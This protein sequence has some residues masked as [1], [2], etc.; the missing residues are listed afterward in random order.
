MASSVGAT[1][2]G[3][4]SHL[5]PPPGSTMSDTGMTVD[6]PVA[7]SGTAPA[8]VPGIIPG[9]P[10]LPNGVLTGMPTPISPAGAPSH[11]TNN[12]DPSR[13][14]DPNNPNAQRII[15]RRAPVACRRCR[16]MRS[17]CIHNGAKP[18]CQGCAAAGVSLDECVFPMRGVPDYDRDYRHPRMKGDKARKDDTVRSQAYSHRARHSGGSGASAS[19]GTIAGGSHHFD[20]TLGAAMST[21]PWDLL[22]PLNQIIEAVE[23]FTRQYFQ[24]GFIPLQAFVQQ[25]LEQP[26]STSP[27]ML[28]GVL[29]VSARMTPSLVS[30]HGG[31]VATAEFYMERASSVALAELY[32]EPTLARCQA[33]YLL[34]LAQQG[35]GYRN[36]S[37]V[38]LGIA[39]RM[40]I[41]MRLHREDTYDLGGGHNGRSANKSSADDL[42]SAPVATTPSMVQKAESA[43]RTLWMLYSQDNLHASPSAPVSLA[44]NDISLLLPCDEDDFNNGVIP[45]TRAALE[46]TPPAR[47]DPSLVSTPARSLFATL[48]QSHQLWGRVLRGA[49]GQAK[50]EGKEGKGYVVG[51]HP[52]DPK[53]E[54]AAI[55]AKLKAWEDSLPPSHL[56]SKDLM[57]IYK[58]QGLDLAYTAITMVTRLC[59]IVIRRAYLS[60]MLSKSGSVQDRAFF[61]KMSG[62]LFQNVRGLFTQID[63]WNQVREA[64]DSTGA[65]LAIFCV[66]LCSLMAAY[67]FKY[68][69]LCPDKAITGE[70]KTMLD[71]TMEIL[72]QSTSVWPLAQRWIE[73]VEKVRD[74]SQNVLLVSLA[75]GSHE[76]GMAEGKDPIPSALHPPPTY[77]APVGPSNTPFDDRRQRARQFG[78]NSPHTRSASPS[79]GNIPFG[80]N[81]VGSSSMVHSSSSGGANGLGINS[82]GSSSR[83][84]PPLRMLLPPPHP[85]NP[86]PNMASATAAHYAPTSAVSSP[87]SGISTNSGMVT[88]TQQQPMHHRVSPHGMAAHASVG[89]SSG[90]IS[91]RLSGSLP[92]VDAA[93]S[94][95]S[96]T[97]PSVSG[98]QQRTLLPDGR[99]GILVPGFGGA[100]NMTNSTNNVE[101]AAG[102]DGMIPHSVY[103]Q[104][105]Q[106]Q[107]HHHP[108]TQLDMSMMGHGSP[109]AA[110]F[111]GNSIMPDF[112]DLAVLPDDGFQNNLQM[113]MNG[114]SVQ[115]ATTW[116]SF[117]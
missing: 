6:L 59:N 97:M 32:Q 46:D 61:E 60:Q 85:S 74:A 2:L 109:A 91:P 53:S 56:W 96:P 105:Q 19:P 106:Q 84:Q 86:S 100:D 12:P 72:Q 64:S 95:I 26:R 54:Y 67:L 24:L 71:R 27:F 112:R 48:M 65:Q 15:K 25:L 23:M 51:D 7:I 87:P 103:P 62:E 108:F 28:L 94:V 52:R 69:T 77:S 35:S 42:P 80:A 21:D 90:T 22:P 8:T 40:A 31:A 47:Q 4:S 88:P 70:G 30:T 78:P 18:P 75:P 57:R 114:P 79:I 5:P 66:Y 115:S 58:A 101:A 3:S 68:P 111:A 63:Y 92:G 76:G 117:I 34:S 93:T 116:D 107:P 29:S 55:S 98:V 113:F 83:R 104:Q 11:Q 1:A 102:L 9:A 14:I 99:M 16:R 49:V 41:L 39:L 13:S 38:N 50:K 17:K 82:H 36:R 89:M 43:R 44:A 110:L 81:G 45:K 10:A 33:F 20:H 37:F 73:S